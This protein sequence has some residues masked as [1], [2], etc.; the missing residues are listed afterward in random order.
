MK[1][2]TAATALIASAT[3]AL[4]DTPNLAGDPITAET[5]VDQAEM[6]RIADAI[7][8]GVDAKDWDLT[9]SFFTDEITVDFT[10]LVGGEPATIPADALIA[11]WSGNLTAEK[12]S[13][14]LRGNHRVTFD[15]PDAAT[16]VSHGYAWNRMESGALP[17]NGGEALWEVWGTYEHGFARTEDGWKVNAMTFTATAERGNPFVRNTPGS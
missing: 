8:A 3:I 17:E 6:V 14:H 9:R 15:G 7:D 16:M 12:T 13:F 2:L 1:A 5:L 4:A 11:G 10:S